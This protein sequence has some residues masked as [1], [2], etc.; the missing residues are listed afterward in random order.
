MLFFRQHS[1]RRKILQKLEET[2][3]F[4]GSESKLSKE[5]GCPTSC[6]KLSRNSRERRNSWR[7]VSSSA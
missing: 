6:T 5:W 2:R 3:F 1:N 7:S 4:W